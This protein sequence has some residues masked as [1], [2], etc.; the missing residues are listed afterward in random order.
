MPA[1]LLLETQEHNLILY[2]AAQKSLLAR[3]GS[4]ELSDIAFYSTAPTIT[5]SLQLIHRGFADT[6]Y[7]PR[8]FTLS[9]FTAPSAAVSMNSKKITSLANG[10]ATTDA[11]NLSQLNAAVAGLIST[12]TADSRYYLAT[13][14]LQNIVAPTAAL[15]L[16]NQQLKSLANGTASTDA[17]NLGQL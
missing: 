15:S 4:F 2:T 9:D 6:T 1:S 3:P 16:N 7:Y 8:V 11:V 12:A 5:N 10:T 13:T 17:V 14:P